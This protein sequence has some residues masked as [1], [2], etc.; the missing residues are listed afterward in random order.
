MKFMKKEL[1]FAIFESD[2]KNNCRDE[3]FS[4]I[5]IL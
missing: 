2:I 1:L 4:F 3:F 5:D